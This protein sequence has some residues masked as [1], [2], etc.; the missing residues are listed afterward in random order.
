LS[1]VLSVFLFFFF[2]SLY[3]LSL[4][5]TNRQKIQWTKERGQIDRQYN[6]QKK[7]DK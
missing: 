1:I 7:E 5:R 4:K 6:G 3:F 2:F